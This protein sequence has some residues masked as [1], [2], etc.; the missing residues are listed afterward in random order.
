MTLKD[1]DQEIEKS[2]GS[3]ED[4]V[5]LVRLTESELGLTSK[6]FARKFKIS[7]TTV[8]RWKNGQHFPHEL[9]V[10]GL[11]RGLRKMIRD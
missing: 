11:L 9:M 5:R 6:E 8:N 4:F 1:F 3:K 7:V 10:P 2:S